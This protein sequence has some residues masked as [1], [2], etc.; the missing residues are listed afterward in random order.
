MKTARL[1]VVV[2]LAILICGIAAQAA[3]APIPPELENE[4]VLGI[5]KQPYHATLMLYGGRAE[6]LAA[7]RYASSWARS[8]NGSWKFHWVPRPEQRP[9]DFYKPSYD[10]SSWKEIPVPSNWQVLGYGTPYYRNLGYT[11]QK[12]WPKVMSEPP[13]TFTAFSERNPV[14]S[15]RREFEVPASWNGRRVFITFDGVDSAFFL[16][17]N[18]EKVGYS[19]NSRNPAE[20]DLTQY[21]RPG[22]KNMI[23][24]EV[25]RY[26]AGSYLEDQDMWRLSGIFRNVTLWSAPQV[27]LRD[28]FVTTDL[29]AQYRDAKLKVSAK[30]HN[31]SGHPMN[32]RKLTVELY[33]RSGQSVS[34]A[35]K[36]VD[37]PALKPDE[38]T[39]VVAIIPV[40]NP[41]KWTAETPELY[42]TVLTLSGE[43]GQ[44]EI[45]STRTGFRKIEVK[46]GV[47]MVNGVAVKLKGANRHEHWPDTGHYVTEERMIRDIELL[48]QVN[49][50][51][52]RTSHYTDDPRWYELCDEYGLY[53]VAEAN[54]EAHGYYNVLDREPRYEKAIVDRNVA[55]VE[56]LKNH[57]SVIIWSLGNEN[58]GGK[59]FVTALN[60]IRAIDTTRLT[61]YEP[62]GVGK[63]VP[64]D[65]DSRMYSSVQ[66]VERFAKQEGRNR[67]FYLCEYVHAMNNSLGSIGEYNDLFDKYPKLMGGAI[68]EWEDQGLWNRR[69]P[70]R[71]YLAYGGGFGEV[72]NDHYFIHKGVVFSD[73]SPKPHYPEVKRV[74]QWVGFS[75]EDLAAGKVLIRNKYAFTNLNKFD[76]SWTVS[77]DGVVVD[78]GKLGRIDLTP[79]E[80]K[81]IAIDFRKL[82]PKPGAEYFL[83]LSFTL[84]EQEKWAKA[85]YEVA[86]AQFKLPFAAPARVAVAGMSPVQ[87][88]QNDSTVTVK[89]S[90]FSVVFDKST[91]GI[92]QIHRE[93]VP[94]LVEGGGP[95]LY[96]WRAPHRNDDDWAGNGWFQYGINSL[97]F[98]TVDMKAEQIDGANVR[99]KTTVRGLGRNGWSIDHT[100]S[101]T[102]RGDGSILVENELMP[103]GDRIVLAR[104]GVRMMLDKR[105][106]QF[107]YLGRGPMENYS[108]RK[109]GS[110]IG[111]FASTVKEQLTPYAKPMECGNHEDVRWAALTSAKLPGLLARTVAEPMQVSA[112]PYTDEQLDMPEYSVDLPESSATVVTLAARTL[113]VG[114]NSCGPRPLEQYVVWSDPVSFS[115]ELRLLEPG[116]K[117]LTTRARQ[118]SV[119]PVTE[120]ARNQQ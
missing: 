8:L 67:P 29:D 91:G 41:A 110:D 10:V 48:K 40:S 116:A 22:Q 4:Q 3:D 68:W 108:D 90:N 5:N 25:Y 100:A 46:D 74:Y 99:V 81:S 50:N 115:Y 14:G 65:I 2:M 11:I 28:F 119:P 97:R 33:N 79:G 77:E 35:A 76:A 102:V 82:T 93:G 66:D 62:F 15:Y 88:A 69:D 95:K 56:E 53:L 20:F 32:A 18:G 94:M 34:G 92:S 112:L 111:L 103:M 104:V 107:T 38:E 37:V 86:T 98:Q 58:G 42:T 23:A 89:G 72:P 114:S 39:E 19:V 31:Y 61:H 105:I 52:V 43:R 63:N 21:V 59:N 73:R 55:N 36:T 16:W 30:V 1:F 54:V 83:Q 80:E 71:P 24:V 60:A 47:F 84:A 106:D 51:H 118:Q 45:I 12:D 75:P 27:H 17:V 70:K 26:N 113:G 78:R 44:D 57:A 13:K 9:V 96:L 6:A 117:D 120:A 87:F 85:G 7:N 49:A 109:R 64:T 101:Y